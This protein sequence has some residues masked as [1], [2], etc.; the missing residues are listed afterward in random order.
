MA[1][2]ELSKAIYVASEIDGSITVIDQKSPQVIARLKT[3]SGARSIR[4]PAE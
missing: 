1:L 3:K 2:S 4:R